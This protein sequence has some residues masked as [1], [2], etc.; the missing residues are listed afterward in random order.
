MVETELGKH[1]EI[2]RKIYASCRCDVEA[3]IEPSGS[4]HRLGKSGAGVEGKLVSDLRGGRPG[5]SQPS[6]TADRD[7]RKLSP[8]NSIS[9]LGVSRRVNP[10]TPSLMLGSMQIGFHSVG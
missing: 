7:V 6:Q 4:P 1:A 9:L 3:R 2:G 5:E 10:Y 8:H